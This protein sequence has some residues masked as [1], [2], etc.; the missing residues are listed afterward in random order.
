MTRA[1]STRLTAE[2][3]LLHLQ[4]RAREKRIWD[5]LNYETESFLPSLITHEKGIFRT[6]KYAIGK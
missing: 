2:R 1:D 6:A 5:V 4:D 3:E